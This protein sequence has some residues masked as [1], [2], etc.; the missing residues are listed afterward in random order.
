MSLNLFEYKTNIIDPGF[1]KFIMFSRSIDFF[2]LLLNRYFDR[3]NFT[4][5]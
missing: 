2:Y 1:N 3:F 4:Q 5:Y